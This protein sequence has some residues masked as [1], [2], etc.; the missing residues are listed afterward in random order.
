MATLLG[1]VLA[2]LLAVA[3]AWLYYGIPGYE[4]SSNVVGDA[5]SNPLSK[6]VTTTDNWF[7]NY[8][9]Y[10][11]LWALVAA[12]VAL[13]ILT[14]LMAKMGKSGFA[15]T[16]SSLA[17][18]SIILMTGFTLF[19]FVMPSSTN[20]ASALTLWDATSSALTLEIMFWVALFFIPI[21][22]GYTFWGY[23][24]MWRRIEPE[25]IEQ[26]SVSNY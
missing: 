14:S 5:P 3:G 18:A 17:I 10:P 7:G 21:I 13:P 26:N 11:I 23:Y 12:S 16:L 1:P 24:K 4:I 20:L 9:A 2:V 15:F 22:L 25:F 6:T 8:T 19:P